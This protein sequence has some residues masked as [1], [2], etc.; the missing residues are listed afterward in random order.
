MWR[1]STC[2][3]SLARRRNIAAECNDHEPAMNP[4]NPTNPGISG[5]H[6]VTAITADAQ[7]NVDFYCGV[8][9]LRLVKRTVNFDDPR[10]YHLYFGDEIGRPGTILT[11]FAWP[12]VPRGRIGPP[13][14]SSTAFAVPE[15]ALGYW[16][17]RLREFAV[18]AAPP[19]ERL[20]EP[21]VTFVDP[22]GMALEL[23]ATGDLRGTPWTEGPVPAEFAIRGFHGVTISEEGYERTAETLTSLMG[24]T[25]QGEEGNRFRYRA[26]VPSGPDRGFAAT[27][28]LLCAPDARHGLMGAGIVHH[29]A[30]RAV[31]ET[32]QAEWRRRI[33]DA[34]LNVSPVMDRKY[35]RSIY[36]REPGGVLFEI[37]TDAPGF[38]LDEPTRELG[39]RLMLP[40]P[41]EA[42]RA[43]L[44]AHLP[45]LRLSRGHDASQG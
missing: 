18:D 45:T 44:E 27:V 35:F 33:V 32:Q 2:G 28:D 38:A 42:R 13:Q 15:G 25:P 36:Y 43:E 8:L 20:G 24:F 22:D 41:F 34:G 9:G 39:A 4:M 10:S 26:G 30:F 29:V 23:V 31:D 12:G 6:H 5:I 11:F 37:A 3:G 16:L 17:A 14:V 19:I 7:R 1:A 40:T 21:V